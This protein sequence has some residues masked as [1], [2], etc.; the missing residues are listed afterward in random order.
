VL[1]NTTKRHIHEKKQ[2][3]LSKFFIL[4]NHD[5]TC[6][7]QGHPSSNAETLSDPPINSIIIHRR[8]Y[9]LSHTIPS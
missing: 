5:S 3:F 6:V 2:R 7:S 1:V 9:C 4:Q 8:K